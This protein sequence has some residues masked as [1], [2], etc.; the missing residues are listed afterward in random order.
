MTDFIGAGEEEGWDEPKF[1]EQARYEANGCPK[2]ENISL[3]L[4]KDETPRGETLPASREHHLNQRK[5]HI[6]EV[7]LNQEVLDA[8]LWAEALFSCS[9]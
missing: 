5:Q 1:D 6:L 9:R 8:G 3:L 2:P 4:G 7:Y